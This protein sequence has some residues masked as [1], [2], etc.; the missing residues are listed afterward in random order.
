MATRARHGALC[1]CVCGEEEH[2]REHEHSRREAAF[3]SAVFTGCMQQDCVHHCSD[4]PANMPSILTVI[5]VCHTHATTSMHAVVH[6]PRTCPY[7]CHTALCVSSSHCHFEPCRM[8]W[9]RWRI[10]ASMTSHTTCA[11][12]STRTYERGTGLPSATKCA[13]FRTTKQQP[14]MLFIMLR[15]P[16]IAIAY[17]HHYQLNL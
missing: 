7:V 15:V 14:V 9:R 10:C 5:P 1:G 11:L 3:G 17:M 4:I 8:C 6:I 2:S 16:L 13:C 12:P